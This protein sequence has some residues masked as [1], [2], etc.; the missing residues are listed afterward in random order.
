ML[1]MLCDDDIDDIELFQEALN[2]THPETELVVS[3]NG[4]Q[5]LSDMKNYEPAIIFLDINMPEMNGWECLKYL[6]SDEKL[7]DTPVVI[8][9]TSSSKSDIEIAKS[10]GAYRLVTKPDRFQDLRKILVSIFKEL[11]GGI[12]GGN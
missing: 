9:T 3:N 1:I 6:K 5:L 7:K 8:Y 11:I 4:K 2:D 12:S 10:N